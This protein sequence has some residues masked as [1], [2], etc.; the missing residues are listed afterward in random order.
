MNLKRGVTWWLE[1]NNAYTSA[2]SLFCYFPLYAVVSKSCLILKK[3]RYLF[4]L[5]SADLISI[6]KLTDH[7]SQFQVKI[8][9]PKIFIQLNIFHKS[10][11]RKCSVR[12]AILKHFAIFP[13]KHQ[14]WSLFLITLQAW[15]PQLY[16]KENRTQLFSF[17]YCQILRRPIL[18]NICKLLL[19]IPAE[20]WFLYRN[21]SSG[22]WG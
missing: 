18:K 8:F 3:Y 7:K 1:K 11:H 14:C 16:Q 4:F 15:S 9:S 2:H 19:L 22:K 20:F 13:G 21:L 10:S 17:E 5:A 12:S 6:F